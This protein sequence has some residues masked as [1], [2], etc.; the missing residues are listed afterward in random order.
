MS[1]HLSSLTSRTGLGLA[2]PLAALFVFLLLSLLYVLGAGA[3]YATIVTRWGVEPFPFG[4]TFGDMQGLL[5]AW[6]CHRLGVDV[7][8][9]DPCDILHRPFNYSPLWLIASPLGLEIGATKAAGWLC[10]LAFLLCLFLLPPPRR[11]RELPVIVL[12]TLSTMVAFAIERGNPDLMIFMLALGAGNLALR[13]SRVRLLA[14]GVGLFAGLLKYYPLTLLALT[15]RERAS[16]FFL[17]NLAALCLMVAFATVYHSEIERGLPTIASGIY[18]GDMFAA[19]NLP[20][21]IAE[22]VLGATADAF[23]RHMLALALYALL[24]LFCAANSARL[25]SRPALRQALAK[26]APEESIFL[27]I[28]GILVIGCFFAGQNVGYRGIFLLLALPGLLAVARCAEDKATQR[29]TEFASQV[30]VL[31]MWGEFFR[32]NLI[33]ALRGLEFG[34]DAVLASW[35]GFWLLRE[36]AWWWSISVL[37][38][39]TTS[40]LWQ[41][42]L[43]RWLSSARARRVAV[44]PPG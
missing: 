40:L 31:L 30:I 21:G 32:T 3:A 19:K 15:V 7:V 17:V 14:Y 20:F 26:L 1:G 29:L 33:S 10:G 28:G 38:A 35:L 24:L 4:I 23:P 37:V 27:A 41:S 36:L 2:A 16:T 25:I 44:L 8:V 18:Y 13:S 34:E 11:P 42:Q 6:E 12:A 39:T 43:G 5:A 9:S 22:T